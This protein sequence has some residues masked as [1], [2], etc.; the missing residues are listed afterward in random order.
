M[1]TLFQRTPVVTEAARDLGSFTTSIKKTEDAVADFASRLPVAQ[2]LPIAEQQAGKI[3]AKEASRAFF[4][5]VIGRLG[6]PGARSMLWPTPQ[7]CGT[8]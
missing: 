1:G 4:I 2:F 3:G 7:T 6:R 5:F 8:L